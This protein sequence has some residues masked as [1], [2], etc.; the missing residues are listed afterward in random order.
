VDDGRWTAAKYQFGGP[1]TRALV[2]AVAMLVLI[3]GGLGIKAALAGDGGGPSGS[4]TSGSASAS[5]GNPSGPTCQNWDARTDRLGFL[6]LTRDGVGL[7]R[8]QDITHTATFT[9]RAS[10][11]HVAAVLRRQ[12][13]GVRADRAAESPVLHITHTRL[14]NVNG[15]IAE[16]STLTAVITS[17]GGC[18]GGWYVAGSH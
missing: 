7:D 13:Y 17:S 14:L 10:A 11:G 5:P 16:R 2:V 4:S 15:V 6:G 12:G 18:Y 9:D 3:L 1:A 8:P